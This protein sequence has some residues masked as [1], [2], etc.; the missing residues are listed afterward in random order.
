VTRAR[1]KTTLETDSFPEGRVRRGLLRILDESPLSALATIGPRGRAHINTAYFAYSPDFEFFFL[2]DPR[3]A[4]ARNLRREPSAALAV[5]RSPQ[6]WGGED[7]GVQLFG[8]GSETRGRTALKAERTYADRFPAYRRWAEGSG[9]TPAQAAQFRTY[10]F[11][12]FLPR[13]FKIL[14]EAEFRGTLFV[15]GTFR[16][17]R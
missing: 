6:T 7:R 10:R 5:F 8:T 16:R 3:S 12:R 15:E 13:R 9:I 11:Y 14:D 17:G 1:P 4:H 2:S